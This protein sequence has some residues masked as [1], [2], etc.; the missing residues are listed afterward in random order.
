MTHF[1]NCKKKNMIDLNLV[2]K[3]I[4]A[5]K[6]V[7]KAKNKNV[8]VD[9][10]L[11]LD[12]TRKSLQQQIDALKFQQKEHGK[13]Q[14]YDQA[15]ALKTKIQILEEEYNTITKDLKQIHLIMPNFMHPDTPIWASEEDNVVIKKVWTPPTF[16]FTP[17]DHQ[18]L[19]ELHDRIDKET[20]SKISWARF[21][22]IKWD[23]ALLQM[24]LINHTFN[25]LGDT[26]IIQQIIKEK[27]LS[28]SYKAFIPILP[29]A[30]L[31]MEV[32]DRMW[33]LYPMDDRY[34][35]PEDKQVFNGSAEHTIG[36]MYMDHTFE[37][38][39]LP[40]RYIGYSSSFRREAGT[41][42]KDTRWI[43]RMHQFDKLEMES[44]SLPEQWE[45]EQELIMGLQEYLVQSLELPYQ[46]VLKCSDDMGSID[47]RGVDIETRL[48]GQNK[49]RETHTSDRMT[50][51]QA[52]RLNTKV[53]RSNG[54]KEFIHMNDATAFAIG[55]ILIAIIENHQTKDAKV[56]IPQ[57]LQK[58]IGKEFIW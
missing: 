30:I 8:D 18:T 38:K 7:C 56:K 17:K 39:D 44:F 49:Y 58:Y 46:V 24:A 10:V 14:E 34:C 42:G 41:Y 54:N 28:L 35:L 11:Q 33:R 25:T 20:A 16:D 1:L 23:L 22:Y 3:D 29:P 57:A 31:K 37:E 15:K 40:L 51:Y 9:K 6:K 43:F 55:R 26:Q 32:M 13:N 19:G 53:K 5:Y 21:A 48:P 12:D 2:R 50:D 4:E 36:P 52:R 47:Y 27:N 45:Q